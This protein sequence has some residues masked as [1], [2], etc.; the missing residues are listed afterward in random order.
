MVNYDI[1]GCPFCHDGEITIRVY[2]GVWQEKRGARTSLGKTKSI[3][4]S[5]TQ[6]VV[7]H[8]CKKCGA[9]AD[10]IEAKL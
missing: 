3:R 6:Y 10:E 5:A 4:K 9:K 8:D 1:I 2:G 7:E